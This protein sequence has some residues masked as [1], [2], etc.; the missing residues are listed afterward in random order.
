MSGI[1]GLEP[2]RE[3]TRFISRTKAR[4][5]SSRRWERAT[6]MTVRS[7]NPAFYVGPYDVE[8]DPTRNAALGMGPTGMHAWLDLLVR[9]SR[10]PAV[11]IAAIHVRQAADAL[12]ELIGAVH[13]D[14]ILNVVFRQFCVGK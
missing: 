8:N 1:H 6:R 11:S 13:T 5:V 4:G 12:G 9:L 10:A 3:A 7:A 14:D 2:G